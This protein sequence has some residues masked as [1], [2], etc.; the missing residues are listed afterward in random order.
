MFSLYNIFLAIL[1]SASYKI[2]VIIIV[3][4]IIIIIIIIIFIICDLSQFTFLNDILNNL[5][6]WSLFRLEKLIVTQLLK[7]FPSFYGTQHLITMFIRLS[8][9]PYSEPH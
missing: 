4:I 1:L 7:N 5:I 2:I 6:P 3:I 8:I 9:G